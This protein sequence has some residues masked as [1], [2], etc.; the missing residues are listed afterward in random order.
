MTE[1]RRGRGSAAGVYQSER[2][3]S[4]PRSLPLRRRRTTQFAESGDAAFAV[5]RLSEHLVDCEQT[6]F[7]TPKDDGGFSLTRR[8]RDRRI[9]KRN[10]EPAVVIEVWKRDAVE[11]GAADGLG[12]AFAKAELPSRQTTQRARTETQE[13]RQEAQAVATPAAPREPEKP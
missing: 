4:R 13:R 3:C 9:D 5:Q 2:C 12:V 10:L 11:A 1:R 8:R 7:R 6:I